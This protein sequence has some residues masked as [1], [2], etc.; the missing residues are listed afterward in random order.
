MQSYRKIV[1]VCRENP[2]VKFEKP[3]ISE[4]IPQKLAGGGGPPVL[5]L[6]LSLRP[7]IAQCQNRPPE[8]LGGGDIWGQILNFGPDFPKIGESPTHKFYIFGNP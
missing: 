2:G 5:K 8:P 1:L 7:P 3:Q 6:E 4:K